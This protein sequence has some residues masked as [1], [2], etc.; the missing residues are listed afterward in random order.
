MSWFFLQ[1]NLRFVFVNLMICSSSLRN[2]VLWFDWI[3]YS[4]FL[5]WWVVIDNQKKKPLSFSEYLILSHWKWMSKLELFLS[6]RCDL[7][8]NGFIWKNNLN[9]GYGIGLRTLSMNYIFSRFHILLCYH[10]WLHIW[11]LNLLCS[12]LLDLVHIS[13]PFGYLVY[14]LSITCR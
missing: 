14:F 8:F 5:G 12:R 4:D 3:N 11:L 13:H 7:S 1:Q 6:G 2:A 10:I 9:F